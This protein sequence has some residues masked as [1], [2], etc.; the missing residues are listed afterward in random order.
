MKWFKVFDFDGNEY[1]VFKPIMWGVALL[2]F[3]L[4]G[5]IFYLDS[6]SGEV[7]GYSYCPNSSTGGCFNVFYNHG[8]CGQDKTLL[9]F[10]HRKGLDPLSP[11]C[12]TEHMFAGQELGDKP[13]FLVTH[14]W[15]FVTG[16]MLIGA[17]FN[18]FIFNVDYRK[19][20]VE[21]VGGSL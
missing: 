16:F 5:Y 7:H 17:F 11:I 13:P 20:K 15:W 21:G 18:H 19:K 14:V 12:S 6:F 4:V 1:K 2:T 10:F 8:N 9:F 3:A